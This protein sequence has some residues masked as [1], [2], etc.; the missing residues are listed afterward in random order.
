MALREHRD[1]GWA[2]RLRE[3]FSPGN[4]WRDENFRDTWRGE[5]EETSQL[6]LNISIL[7]Y[8]SNA[9]VHSKYSSI[10]VQSP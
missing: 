7:A 5:K 4:S 10:L 9:L 1:P 6:C 8:M 2:W 3:V